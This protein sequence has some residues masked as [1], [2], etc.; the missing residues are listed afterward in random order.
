MRPIRALYLATTLASG[1]CA[2][3]PTLEI[4]VYDRGGS[5]RWPLGQDTVRVQ[6]VSGLDDPKGLAGLELGIGGALPRRVFKATDLAGENPPFVVPGEGVA[7]VTVRLVQ[8]GQVVAGGAEEWTLEPEVEWNLDVARVPW[9]PSEIGVMDLENP[10]CNWFWCHR[11]WR[12]PIADEA[13]N[14]EDEALWVTLYRA[15]PDEC[16]DL[17]GGWW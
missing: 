9:P 16:A 14:Y 15:H 1:A 10:E 17:C 4:T 12:F 2:Q 7:T 13:A 8:D 3:D 5:Q 6:I 11:N